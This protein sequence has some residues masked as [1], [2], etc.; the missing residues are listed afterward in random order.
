MERRNGIWNGTPNSKKNLKDTR[1]DLFSLNH[2]LE[3]TSISIGRVA[4][5]SLICVLQ[6]S[7]QRLAVA[8]VSLAQAHR[9]QTTESSSQESLAL[10]VTERNSTLS[11]GHHIDA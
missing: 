10:F 9:V 4:Q 6:C 3:L 11:L 2:S 8:H 5:R 1:F 7:P